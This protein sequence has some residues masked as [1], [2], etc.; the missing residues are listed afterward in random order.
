MTDVADPVIARKVFA[1]LAEMHKLKITGV[2]E[3]AVILRLLQ[4]KSFVIK[5]FLDKIKSGKWST[6]QKECL[7]AIKKLTSKE[8]IDFLLSIK[9]TCKPVFC[10]NDTLHLNII[11]LKESD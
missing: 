5:P 8:E 7:K 6:K 4:D 10:H 1:K 3:E 11:Q 9:P 2:E